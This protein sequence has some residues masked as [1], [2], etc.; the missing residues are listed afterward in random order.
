MIEVEEMRGIKVVKCPVCQGS[1]VYVNGNQ[2]RACQ[3]IGCV[4]L[5]SANRQLGFLTRQISRNEHNLTTAN[6]LNEF[7]KIIAVLDPTKEAR[8]AEWQEVTLDNQTA[9]FEKYRFQDNDPTLSE[10]AYEGIRVQ[11]MVR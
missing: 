5:F 9:L 1:K 8:G 3:G 6:W 4:D 11:V 10:L 2:C 7:E